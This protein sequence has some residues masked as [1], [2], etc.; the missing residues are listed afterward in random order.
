MEADELINALRHSDRDAFNEV[1][2]SY[3]TQLLSY[4]RLM[5]SPQTAEDLVHDVFIRLWNNRETLSPEISGGNLR[6]FLFR[7][8]YNACVSLIRK[9]ISKLNHES[10]LSKQIEDEI[11]YWDWDR[12]DAVRRLY[13]KDI[14][15]MIEKA[16]SELPPKCRQVFLMSYCEG[17][18]DKHIAERLSL[19]LSTVE[20]HIHNALVRLRKS[21]GI[22]D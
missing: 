22:G 5:V 1:Y 10:W 3:Y 13:D 20:N 17:L 16:V 2:R 6:A 4:A 21:I 18:S 9:R 7:S 12:N 8:V 19:S 15:Q 11:N 14:A